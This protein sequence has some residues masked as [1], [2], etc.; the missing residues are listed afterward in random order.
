MLDEVR[1]F[2]GQLSDYYHELSDSADQQR[3]KLLL[4][5][6]SDHE[7]HLQESLGAYEEDASK[8]LMDTWVDCKYCDEVL[9]TCQRTPIAQETSVDGVIRA[10]MDID[11]CLIRF[12]REVAEKVNSQTIRDVFRNLI[13]LE[14]GELRRLALSALQIS[15][16]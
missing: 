12:Y 2:H 4:D 16:V 5:H 3:V 9:A 10:T 15:D 6:M 11:G 1:E 13:D 8:Q 14:E 7:R